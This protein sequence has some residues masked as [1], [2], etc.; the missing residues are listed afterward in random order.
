MFCWIIYALLGP[1][2]SQNSF[3][4]F[5]ETTGE[6]VG[7]KTGANDKNKM[8]AERLAQLSV[9][10]ATSNFDE[11]WISMHPI[12]L[13]NNSFYFVVFIFFV[14]FMVFFF[15]QFTYIRQYFPSVYYYL[16]RKMGRSRLDAYKSGAKDINAGY[17]SYLFKKKQ[18]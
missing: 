2:Q 14:D 8:S 6:T 18:E 1:I 9:R 16:G 4:A 11:A 7:D 12:L 3:N 5:T 17:F 13:V 10:V 15:L